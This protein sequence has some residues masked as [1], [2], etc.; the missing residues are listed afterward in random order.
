LTTI[1]S[2]SFTIT[3]SFDLAVRRETVSGTIGGCR[4]RRTDPPCTCGPER[5]VVTAVKIEIMCGDHPISWG[6]MYSPEYIIGWE[7]KEGDHWDNH[8]PYIYAVGTD[9]P[10]RG[11][12]LCKRVLTE[13]HAI[14]RDEWGATAIHLDATEMGHPVYERMGYVVAPRDQGWLYRGT[15]MT[16]TFAKEV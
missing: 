6:S 9:G 15:P 13:L 14:A 12:G 11:M 2:D 10:F 5:E 1:S 3:K 8:I 4:H 7:V 16:I